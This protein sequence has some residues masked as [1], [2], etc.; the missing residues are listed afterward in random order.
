[1][2]KLCYFNQDNLRFSAFE[3]HAEL[4]ASKLSR[5]HLNSP[6]LNPLFYYIWTLMSGCHAW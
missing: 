3:R 1:M 6:D 5:V 2:T 4:A